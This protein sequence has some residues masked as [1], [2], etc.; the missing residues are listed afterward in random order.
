[1]VL[2]R[3]AAAFRKKMPH[4]AQRD[5]LQFVEGDV[6]GFAFPDGP[7]THVIHAG[8]TSSAPVPPV[9]MFDTIVSGT[10][11]V[12][13]FAVASG[14]RKLLF[15]SSGAVYGKQPP[16]LANIP[17]DYP[18]SPDPCDPG[19]AYGEGKRAAELLCALFHLTYGIETKIARCFAFAGPHLPLEA[20]F[21]IGNFIRDA[22]RGGPIVV[23]NGAP[24]RSYL[25]AADLAIW[26]W[27]ILFKG[28]PARPYNV[29]SDQSLS[30]AEIAR[31]VS[32]MSG[33]AVSGSELIPTPPSS[34]YV[35][36]TK[37]AQSELGL[38]AWTSLREGIKKT[39][40][41][42]AA[43]GQAILPE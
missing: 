38:A 14:A 34:R 3:N 22:M 39:A 37:R 31:T 41:W 20:H 17:E 1:V 11:R 7:F 28:A 23:N 24:F 42:N 25:Y 35:P 4:L 32:Q 9:E 27:T 29:G 26:L 30:V 8:T 13:E 40:C 10:R 21:A 18:G 16:E 19:S 43:T 12:I 5:D 15:T 6:R 2:T 33:V 36:C